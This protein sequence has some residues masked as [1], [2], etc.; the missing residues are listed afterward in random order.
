MECSLRA[1]PQALSQDV[2]EEISRRLL[3]RCRRR[4]L[5][6]WDRNLRT[7]AAGLQDQLQVR[8]RCG[9][10]SGDGGALLR[11]LGK[12]KSGPARPIATGAT[13]AGTGGGAAVFYSSLGFRPHSSCVRAGGEFTGDA[14]QTLSSRIAGGGAAAAH[15]HAAQWSWQVF[16]ERCEHHVQ[17]GELG[18]PCAAADA[19]PELAELESDDGPDD[20]GRWGIELLGRCEDNAQEDFCKR[21][22]G[23][24]LAVCGRWPAEDAEEGETLALQPGTMDF[25]HKK[26]AVYENSWQAVDSAAWERWEWR[27]AR[28]GPDAALLAAL[29]ASEESTRSR[30]TSGGGGAKR[31]KNRK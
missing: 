21:M 18:A 26:P 24:W 15:D 27:R 11:S 29:N 9:G 3:S 20:G 1:N 19:A 30:G 25:P 4:P 31:Q 2:C 17:A 13:E 5:Y 22:L 12:K 6:V 16:R 7:H 23:E 10:G 28:E 8:S 14:S